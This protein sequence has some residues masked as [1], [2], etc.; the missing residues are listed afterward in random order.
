[1]GLFGASVQI[2]EFR[3]HISVWRDGVHGETKFAAKR[4]P[5][6]GRGD[7]PGESSCVVNL[8]NVPMPGEDIANAK[9]LQRVFFPVAPGIVDDP[10][11]LGVVRESMVALGGYVLN[12]DGHLAARFA[13]VVAIT[14]LILA[15][16]LAM[17]AA[18][19]L[20]LQPRDFFVS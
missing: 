4:A 13:P 20:I 17:I 6:G 3:R 16:V 19:G 11:G 7:M 1:M 15:L 9:L 5:T 8:T 2:H 18:S 12:R 10:V 14:V